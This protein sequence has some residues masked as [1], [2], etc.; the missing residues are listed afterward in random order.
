MAPSHR[1][2]RARCP[3]NT[4]RGRV[5]SSLLLATQAARRAA[6]MSSCDASTAP[7]TR[8][9]YGL[10]KRLQRAGRGTLFSRPRAKARDGW[11]HR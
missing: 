8:A 7:T 3:S 4:M 5:T 2:T 10:L 6:S 9:A 11:R 1:D